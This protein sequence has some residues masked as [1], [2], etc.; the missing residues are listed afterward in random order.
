MYAAAFVLLGEACRPSETSESAFIP[1]TDAVSS[2]AVAIPPWPFNGLTASG[3]LTGALWRQGRCL[4]VWGGP[5]EVTALAFPPGQA[6]WDSEGQAL[7]FKDRRYAIGS[8]VDLAGGYHRRSDR[9][10]K[11]TG[12]PDECPGESVWLAG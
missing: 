2:A 1:D 6:S 7:L 3:R 12:L 10:L 9:S 4:V 11:V 8:K 5:G